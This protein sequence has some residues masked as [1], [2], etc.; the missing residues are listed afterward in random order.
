MSLGNESGVGTGKLVRARVGSSS[1]QTLFPIKSVNQMFPSEPVT[2]PPAETRTG[3]EDLLD[4]AARSDEGDLSDRS[5]RKPDVAIRA[6]RNIQ[7]EN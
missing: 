6:R 7:R 3:K 1:R 2:I 5:F 4:L